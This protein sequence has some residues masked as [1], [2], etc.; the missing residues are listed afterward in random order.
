MKTAFVYARY[1]SNNQR[2]ESIDA[3]LRA[4]REYCEREQIMIVRDFV[5]RARSA[6]TDN[7]PHFLEMI[8][9]ASQTRV[10][11]VIVHKLDRF[12]RNRFDSAFYRRELKKHGVRLLSVLERFDDTP[13]SVILES[14]LEGFAE[15]YSKN[16]AREVRKGMRE[17]ALKCQHLG[18]R[19]PYGYDLNE[20]RTYRINEAQAENVRMIFRMYADGHGYSEILDA[21]M[22]ERTG[23]GKFFGKNSLTEILRNEKYTGVYIFNRSVAKSEYGTRNNHASKDASEIIRIPDGMP[24]I[25]DDETFAIC[26]K[27]MHNRK[28]NG[29]GTAKRVYLLSGLL[30]CGKCGASMHGATCHA[31]RNKTEYSYYA[32]SNRTRLRRCDLP[33]FSA[34]MLE[35]AVLNTVESLLYFT[36][37]EIESIYKIIVNSVP[38]QNDELQKLKTQRADAERRLK[39]LV[40]VASDAPTPTI[41]SEIAQLEDQIAD[42]DARILQ[43]PPPVIMPTLADVAAFCRQ[44]LQIRK[45][46]PTEQRALLNR[47]ID[48][49]VINGNDTLDITFRLSAPMVEAVSTIDNSQFTNTSGGGVLLHPCFE[50]HSGFYLFRRIKKAPDNSVAYGHS[51]SFIL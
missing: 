16:L 42:L 49:I 31:G 38:D 13:E 28:L 12:A 17:N 35:D 44:D 9:A 20:D 10:D 34:R 37:D 23:S 50:I 45:K 36:D 18:G 27:R 41:G 1:S 2:E 33:R 19:P 5:D 39:N 21:L 4:I 26:R 40:F 15:Y 7:R 30:V 24:R 43:A 51:R 25:I 6:T 8:E 11:Y 32:C 3:Q 46:E 48:K 22:G 14:V 29:S 47:L